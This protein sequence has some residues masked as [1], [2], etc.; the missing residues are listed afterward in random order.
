[1]PG[2]ENPN[3]YRRNNEKGNEIYQQ[4]KLV[5]HAAAN[6]R[7]SLSN[8]VGAVRFELT[9]TGTPFRIVGTYYFI[10]QYVTS[11]RSLPICSMMPNSAQWVDAKLTQE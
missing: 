7:N 5:S 3:S 2:A 10:N 4:E 9:T 8:L 1:V 6:A 11:M